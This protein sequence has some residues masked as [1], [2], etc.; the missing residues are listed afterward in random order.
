MKIHGMPA[1]LIALIKAFYRSTTARVL[2]HNNSSQPFD[3]RSGVRQGCVL[4]LILFNYVDDWIRGKALHEEDGIELAPG[5]RLTNLD[6]ADD[7]A[8]LASSFY[9]LQSVVSRVTV[10]WH[11]HKFRKDAV[12]FELHPWQGEGT[13]GD[14]RQSA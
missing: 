11:V 9:G 3:I 2:V 8:L 7:L 4:S 12:M 13:P 6:F 10:G 1:K 14:N 5:R